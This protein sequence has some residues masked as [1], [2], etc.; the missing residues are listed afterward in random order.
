[1]GG[2][3]GERNND[4][5]F[6]LDGDKNQQR[7]YVG[8]EKKIKK[9]YEEYEERSRISQVRHV[10]STHQQILSNSSEQ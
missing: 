2:W 6:P 5:S 8:S 9:E 7:K 1:M 4:P 10:D 3:G